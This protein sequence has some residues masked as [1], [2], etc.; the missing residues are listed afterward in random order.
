M[1]T[2]LS[3]T[4]SLYHLVSVELKHIHIREA[5]VKVKVA[6]DDLLF[7]M[8][9]STLGGAVVVFHACPTQSLIKDSNNSVAMLQH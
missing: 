8:E 2:N 4:S 7:L 9:P 6:G 3:N 5:F 1:C